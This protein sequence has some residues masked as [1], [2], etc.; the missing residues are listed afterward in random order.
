MSY[1]WFN[2]VLAALGKRIN[3][4]SLSNLYGRTS[5]DK[6]GSKEIQSIILASNPLQ[7][8]NGKP[9]TGIQGLMGNIKVVEA[10]TPEMQKAAITKELGDISWADGLF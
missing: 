2:A 9:N 1:V 3:F 6:K 8:G 10:K 5:F 7:K 4:E